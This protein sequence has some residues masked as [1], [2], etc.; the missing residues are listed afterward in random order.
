MQAVTPLSTITAT[1]ELTF[2]HPGASS[3]QD[4][5]MIGYLLWLDEN[6]KVAQVNA[7]SPVSIT[8]NGT[9]QVTVTGQGPE[10]AAYCTAVFTSLN[11]DGLTTSTATPAWAT[12]GEYL[13]VS[14]MGSFVELFKYDPTTGL[15]CARAS[16]LLRSGPAGQRYHRPG[17]RLAERRA[18]HRR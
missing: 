1:A 13:G 7:G 15:F 12:F 17:R 4:A 11:L 9:V 3:G 16:Q 14:Y 18:A 2:D 6:Y 8:I 5:Q 10:N